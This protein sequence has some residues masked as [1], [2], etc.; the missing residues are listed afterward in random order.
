MRV[1]DYIADFLVRHGVT[2]AFGIPG[3][4]VLELIYALDRKEG[5]TPHLCYHEQSAGFA[6]CGYAQVSGRLGVAYA[7]RGPGFSN[8]IT[9]IA[10]AWSDS[11]PVLFITG[12]ACMEKNPKMRVVADQELDTCEI[13]KNITKYAVRV[14][15]EELLQIEFAKAYSIAMS[16]RK[17][18]VFMDV[19]SSIWRKDI[20]VRVERHSFESKNSHCVEGVNSVA[21]SIHDAQRPVFLIGDGLHQTGME[22]LFYKLATATGIPVISSR[23]SHDV[24]GGEECYFGYIGS[25]GIRTANFVLS[26]ADLIVAIGNRLCFPTNSLSYKAIT[27][28][29]HIIRI[30][31]DEGELEHVIPHSTVHKID[32]EDFLFGMLDQAKDYGTHTEWVG[33]CRSLRNQLADEDLNDAVS[34]IENE[35]NGVLNDTIIVND[36]GNNEFWVSKACVHLGIRNRTLYSKSFGSLGSAL[37]KSIGA[38]YATKKPVLCFIGDQGLQMNIQELQTIAQNDLP[39]KVVVL[40]NSISGMIKDREDMLYGGKHLHTT[41]DSGYGTPNFEMIAVAYGLDESRFKVL[42]INENIGL[43]P[44]LPKENAIQDMTPPL[45]EEIYKSLNSL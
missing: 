25:H 18:P 23:Y 15:N 4:V 28:E 38:Y 8:L 31:V 13:V 7:T 9:A 12:H 22:S 24:I 10:D 44:Q 11:V 27:E 26:K 20:D 35:L 6:A 36:V 33:I 32:I 14:D 3:G 16:G 34:A 5:I 2:D 45:K 29:T 1:S 19:A 42:Y 39:I 30:E 40:N 41:K 21:R 17:G 43:T 37:G